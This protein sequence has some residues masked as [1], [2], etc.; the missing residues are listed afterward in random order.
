MHPYMKNDDDFI[1]TRQSLLSRLRNW[2]DQDS[3]K[4]FFDTYWRLIYSAAIKAGLT[5]AEAQDAV[6]ETVV[7]VMKA[8]PSF[9]YDAK[10]G[11]F[12]N[13]LLGLT[14]W[15]ITDQFRKRQRDIDHQWCDTSAPTETDTV[16]RL[17]D[18]QGLQ[19]E[20]MWDEEW[21]KNL[22]DAAVERVKRKVD[23][24]QYQI[25]DLYVLKEWSV[26]KVAQTLKVNRGMVYLTKH[27]VGKLI[28]K[29]I[30]Y[31]QSKITT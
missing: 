29:E 23:P 11:S 24:K 20:A 19:L 26:S 17:P 1:P 2:S 25:F 21:E 16:E 9:A 18:L 3:W 14:K 15:R 30:G 12:K 6:Q 22:V 31:L 28:K 8:M 27:R 7:S 13:W 5:D 10:K 4:E